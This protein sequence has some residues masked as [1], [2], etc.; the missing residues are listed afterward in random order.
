MIDDHVYFG[1]ALA[2]LQ[3]DGYGEVV[4]AAGIA[5]R[6]PTHSAR[7]SRTRMCWR[8]RAN[9]TIK[10]GESSK[11]RLVADDI[12]DNSNAAGGQRLNDYL[13]PE[14]SNPFDMRTDMPV[15]QR[16][17]PPQRRIGDLHPEFDRS[18]RP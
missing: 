8:A 12:L 5:R 10:W 15:E 6:A 1:L 9:L 3:H 7:T 16:L 2:D 14:L 18:A 17:L 13:A 11:L 4:A